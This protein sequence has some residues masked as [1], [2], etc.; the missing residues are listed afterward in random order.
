M[1][2]D[3]ELE[4]LFAEKLAEYQSKLD[5]GFVPLD[6]GGES[7]PELFQD[8]TPGLNRA[9]QCLELLHLTREFFVDPDSD[10]KT[11]LP[12]L[13]LPERI[14]RFELLECLGVG[15][16]GIVYRALD[17]VVSR[18]VALKTP[19]PE[20]LISPNLIARFAWEA[21]AAAQLD[22]PNIVPV[23]ESGVIGITP[24]L[25]SRLAPG[26]TLAKWRSTQTTV[27][28][29]L[30][31]RILLSLAEAVAH[32]HERG[33]LHRDL[34]PGN[35]LLVPSDPQT[36]ENGLPFIPQL[37]DF[38]LAKCLDGNQDK[39][40][41]GIVI[42]TLRNMAPE[43]IEGN[44]SNV[45]AATDIYGLGAILYEL[46]TGQVPFQAE[47]DAQTIRMILHDDPPSMRT[48]HPQI[49]GDLELICLKCLQKNPDRRYHSARELARDLHN[50]LVGDPILA[51]P[52]T[53]PERLWKWAR[54]KPALATLVS[55][56]VLGLPLLLIISVWYNARFS[57]LLANARKLEVSLRRRAYVSDMR[58]AQNARDHGNV[59]EMRKLLERHKPA[60]GEPDVRNFPWWF[61]TN[62]DKQSSRILTE[63]P[64][65]VNAVAI[66]PDS[67]VGATGGRD[68]IIRL[69]ALPQ[70]TPLR[71]WKNPDL[72][73]VEALSFSRDSSTLAVADE[74]G[75]LTLYNIANGEQLFRIHAHSGW[76]ADVKFSPLADQLA[77][78]GSDTLIKIWNPKTGQLIATLQG[79]PKTVR[80][81]AFDPIDPV[82][83]S[84][85]EHDAVRLWDLRTMQPDS[86]LPE[87][88]FRNPDPNHWP[89]SLVFD[90]NQSLLVG[91]CRNWLLC[92][93]VYTTHDF[94]F[95]HE[96]FVEQ[97]NPRSLSWVSGHP[98]V[99]GLTNSTL[100]VTRRENPKD[101]F[102]TL[103]GH[104]GS[105]LSVA[106][107]PDESCLLS[108]SQD[109][110][111][112][113]WSR[114]ALQ[115][116]SWKIKGHLHLRSLDGPRI[117]P[118]TIAVGT[119]GEELVI[120]RISD[121]TPLFQC[122]APPHGTFAY[123]ESG[124]RLIIA[125]N[126]GLTLKRIEIPSGET[127]WSIPLT[128]PLYALSLDSSGTRAALTTQQKEIQILDVESGKL[129]L[130]F[131]LPDNP[132]HTCFLERDGKP[133][134]LIVTC[135][136]GQVRFCDVMTGKITRQFHAHMTGTRS[137][138]L[139]PD[140]RF[141]ATGGE[142]RKARIWNLE[143]LAEVA[144]FSHDDMVRQV[145]FLS[146]DLLVTSDSPLRVWS[147]TEGVEM[148]AFPKIC[149]G[150][151]FAVSPDGHKIFAQNG[152]VIRLLDGT[153][154]SA[155][156]PES[157]LRINF[158]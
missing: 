134:E 136:D 6:P 158:H 94:G 16:F 71:E 155:H 72:T 20:V 100:R 113:L 5:S 29:L 51:R 59:G 8:D 32:A 102:T 34:S 57:E 45:T 69:W 147:I 98:L 28:P 66:T 43:Q 25:V 55:T 141:L 21:K 7:D 87:G 30:A 4:N 138:A 156:S 139:S 26:P 140:Q 133:P 83:A 119:V 78:A 53:I 118:A 143:T 99:V 17:P 11:T 84:A 60:P 31:A 74:S 23:Y 110:T 52:S 1:T 75:F 149:D 9:R 131:E 79:H 106:H 152:A 35:V 77:T 49:P 142:D 65:G 154:G 148:L 12:A 68:G 127:R 130:R 128:S 54:K 82:L 111:V 115:D 88:K 103:C 47:S 90:P 104:L 81:L 18:E 93:W 145:A 46:L 124:Q 22:H 63:H 108:G 2:P 129:G 116:F 125:D 123:S 48:S 27:D 126:A 86:R 146:D 150:G 112:R 61:L 89:R 120:F 42:G 151:G 36:T 80:A 97:A 132:F 13:Q 91:G 114:Q 10:Q 39:T 107:A 67:K 62:R 58:M 137:L 64:G 109:G 95:L 38:G 37:T 76:I 101:T 14:G 144:S 105:I 44:K 85:G 3:Q 33:V 121:G 41:T 122:K 70:G 40:R 19:R 24:Y 153:P 73:V 56:A 117:G 157:S 96:P 50:F 135:G 15:G 92:Q